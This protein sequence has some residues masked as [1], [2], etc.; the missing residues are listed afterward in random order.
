MK[1]NERKKERL[2]RKHWVNIPLCVCNHENKKRI[3]QNIYIRNK[4]WNIQQAHKTSIWSAM[5][6]ETRRDET[7]ERVINVELN[8]EKKK[9]TRT[10][11]FCE[12]F[13]KRQNEMVQMCT[14]PH[15]RTLSQ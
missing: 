13:L 7:R 6:Y 1:Q 2:E 10:E 8:E 14:T 9:K 4:E 3:E 5:R 15:I 12:M 11:S